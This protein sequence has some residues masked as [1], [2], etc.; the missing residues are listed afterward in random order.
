M[1]RSNWAE[2]YS[3]QESIVFEKGHWSLKEDREK[4]W[5]LYFDDD[6]IYP[7]LDY[8]RYKLF[9][10]GFLMYAECDY[11]NSYCLFSSTEKKPIFSVSG[12]NIQIEFDDNLILFHTS[13]G[14]VKIYDINTFSPVYIA[15]DN[16]IGLDI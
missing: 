14:N 15:K 13:N 6:C 11:S 3:N 10:H 16:Q 9:D 8:N 12:R 5:S 7:V 4:S 2:R 1:S